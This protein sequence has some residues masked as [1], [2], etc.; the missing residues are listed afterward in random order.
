[1]GIEDMGSYTRED[2]DT[3]APYEAVLAIVNPFEREVTAKRM[4]EYASV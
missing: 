3:P 1:M 2:F 4:A